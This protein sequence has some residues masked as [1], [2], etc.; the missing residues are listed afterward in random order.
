[1]DIVFDLFKRLYAEYNRSNA[2]GN[3]FSVRLFKSF[4]IDK[5]VLINSHVSTYSLN[6]SNLIFYIYEPDISGNK[7]SSD[8]GMIEDPFTFTMKY[9]KTSL[10]IRNCYYDLDEDSFISSLTAVLLL[11]NT[12]FILF[13]EYDKMVKHLDISDGLKNIHN[14]ETE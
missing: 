10:D 9:E 5:G 13:A 14:N 1:M 7:H 11:G 3:K 6:F 4:L 8:D 2:V 12:V